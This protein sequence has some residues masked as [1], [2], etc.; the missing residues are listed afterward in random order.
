MFSLYHSSQKQFT[1]LSRAVLVASNLAWPMHICSRLYIGHFQL[2][3]SA[4][5]SPSICVSRQ[6]FL[7][8]YHVSF[9]KGY[10]SV[11]Y[12]LLGE[13]RANHE[14]L[15]LQI[16]QSCKHKNS[17]T[18]KQFGSIFSKKRVKIKIQEQFSARFTS[19]TNCLLMNMSRDVSRTHI[20][21]WLFNYPRNLVFFQPE[22]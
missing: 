18:L 14:Q 3:V 11:K 4:L 19:Q 1:I 9:M 2:Q 20:T 10:W 7:V 6:L 12:C 17:G 21:V 22:V 16:S 15:L 13:S 5:T 8:H